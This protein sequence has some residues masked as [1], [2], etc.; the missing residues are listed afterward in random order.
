MLLPLLAL[1]APAFTVLRH[2]SLPG[3]GGW[4]YLTVDH[5]AH[6]LFIAR[7]DRVQIMDTERERVVGE[8]AD[9]PGVHGVALCG[10]PRVALATSGTTNTVVAFDPANGAE[11]RRFAVGA[12][13]DAVVYDPKTK[14]FVVLNSDGRSAS[15]VDPEHLVVT[16]TIPLGGQPEFAAPDG[17]GGV[18]VNLEDKGRV[19]RIDLGKRR[20]AEGWSLTPGEGPTGLAYSG[21]LV[22]SACANG[23]MAVLDP[24]H[25]T[26]R[27]APIGKGPDAAAVDSRLGLAFASNGEDGTLSI[28]STKD[29]SPV[30]TLP[31][32]PGARTMALD[33]ESHRIYLI[34]RAGKGAEI[35]VVGRAV[36]DPFEGRGFA[37]HAC[38]GALECY[39]NRGSSGSL[40]LS[41]VAVGEVLFRLSF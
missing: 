34:A 37:L 17:R 25:G 40:R 16:A 12:K 24:R 36:F 19:E 35:L 14:R 2:I 1:A 27:T 22:Y 31:T 30:Q 10:S 6:R 15:V 29:L 9:V 5:A 11:F 23:R 21:G 13:P 20:V 41:E 32:G 8:V 39:Q 33:P 26:V 3:E 18:F 4:D 7:G 38:K 28:V